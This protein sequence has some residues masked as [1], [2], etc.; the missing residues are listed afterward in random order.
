M[1]YIRYIYNY[2]YTLRVFIVN[3]F[4]LCRMK[5]NIKTQHTNKQNTENKNET[6]FV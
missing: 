2:T 4:M 6:M 5:K 3:V 1:A